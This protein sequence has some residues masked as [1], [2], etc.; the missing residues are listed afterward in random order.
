M[1]CAEAVSHP[2]REAFAGR[3]PAASAKQQKRLGLADIF[4]EVDEEVRQQRYRELWQRF[5]VYIIAFVVILI[6]SV[7]GYQIWQSQSRSAKAAA[8][9]RYVA[10]ME[11]LRSNEEAGLDQLS[12]FADPSADGYALLAAFEEAAVLARRDDLEAASEIWR[13]IAA[14]PSAGPALQGA[15]ELMDIVHQIDSAD[16]DALQTR[17]S[18]LMASNASYAPMAQELSAL[19]A[20]RSGDTELAI[21]QLRQ[22]SADLSAPESIRLRAGRLLNVL[23]DPESGE[24]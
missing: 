18:Q 15:A 5:G 14:N 16:P 12:T 6:L 23:E 9:D 1:A 22:L 11:A 4:R 17:L 8:S 3:P 10:M 21:D 13:R 20:I 7:A 2:P 24:W 19:V